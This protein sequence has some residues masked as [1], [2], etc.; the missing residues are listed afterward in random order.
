M[1]SECVG[2]SVRNANAVQEIFDNH[3]HRTRVLNATMEV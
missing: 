2:E 1:R 3:S